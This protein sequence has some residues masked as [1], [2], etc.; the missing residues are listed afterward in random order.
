M[1]RKFQGQRKTS[2]IEGTSMRIIIYFGVLCP[3]LLLL[4]LLF[5][6]ITAARAADSESI[7]RG[8]YVVNQ[9]GCNDCHSPGYAFSMETL[10]KRSGSQAM[11]LAGAARG[12]RPML[13]IYA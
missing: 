2:D 4:T 11:L 5:T 7:A 13:L 12:E 6:N 10:L 1:L 9:A 3:M 8:R